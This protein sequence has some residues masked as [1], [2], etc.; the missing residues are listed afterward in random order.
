MPIILPPD[1]ANPVA[2]TSVT[3]ADG[4][5][6]VYLDVDHAG[7]VLVADFSALTPKPL[8]VRFY[9]GSVL[10]RSGDLAWA[11]GGEATAYDHEAPLGT[12]AS[13]TAVPVFADGT[14][15]T[16]SQSAA[17]TIPFDI[18]DKRSV[19]LK[20]IEDPGLSLK[21]L[22]VLPLP[23]F[24]R[25]SNASFLRVPGSAYPLGTVDKRSARTA[26]YHFL[27]TGEDER[28]ALDLLLDSGVL[29]LQ[30]PTSHHTH[31]LYC[32]PGDTSEDPAGAGLD[33]AD[34]EW[35]VPFTE[36]KRPPTAGSPFY[37]P[38]HSYADQYATAPTY[39][40]RL[41]AWPTYA[42]A[43]ET[44]YAIPLGITEESGGIGDEGS[45]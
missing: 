28:D 30:H 22:P 33:D 2:P 12:A 44:I 36:V 6:T 11:P 18:S 7:A 1:T 8:K 25:A 41:I 16:V 31:D 13:W 45:P 14:T 39:T 4:I 34:R 29:L 17:L 19:W 42:D 20:S 32:I 3:S 24:V 27:T 9:R 38:G 43:M 26:E 35:T 5:L 37:Y 10:V 40:E 23:T 15:G 21:L